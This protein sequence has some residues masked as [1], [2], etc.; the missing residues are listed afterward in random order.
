MGLG[1]GACDAPGMKVFVSCFALVLA[2]CTAGVT[3]AYGAQPVHPAVALADGD[4]PLIVPDAQIFVVQA[5]AC[6]RPL[7]E[8]GV[9]L[10]TEAAPF[11]SLAP[12]DIIVFR[13]PE[14]GQPT[15]ER[16][17]ARRDEAHVD[18]G[19]TGCRPIGRAAYLGR[20]FGV[21]YTR[22]SRKERSV[23]AED[24]GHRQGAH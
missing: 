20:V 5:S 8:A 1:A 4:L 7:F 15:V 19:G 16:V 21:V 22:A 12:G 6:R 11:E 2:G 10:F 3:A 13:D 24:R 9:S 17:L 14:T 23:A 18:A